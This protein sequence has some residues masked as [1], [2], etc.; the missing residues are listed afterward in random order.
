MIPKDTTSKP[1]N[2]FVTSKD[3][4]SKH[5]YNMSAEEYELAYQMQKQIIDASIIKNIFSPTSKDK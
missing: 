4:R 2:T 3:F 1:V 5:M